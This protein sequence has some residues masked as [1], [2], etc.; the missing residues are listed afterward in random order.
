MEKAQRSQR[1]A[2]IDKLFNSD[3]HSTEHPQDRAGVSASTPPPWRGRHIS[4]SACR[5]MIRQPPTGK[6]KVT[7]RWMQITR[8][9]TAK[10]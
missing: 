4:L 2:A 7:G 8:G 3:N 10:S 9:E 5:R 6:S 1:D